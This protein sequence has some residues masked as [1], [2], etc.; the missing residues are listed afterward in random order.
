MLYSV[1]SVEK[2]CGKER[3]MTMKKFVF[4]KANPVWEQGKEREK[5]YSLVFQ[6]KIQDTRAEIHIACS[7]TYQIFI[8]GRFIAA[9][10]ARAAHGMYNVDKILL[11]DRLTNDA[12]VVD[13]LVSGYNTDTFQTLNQPSFLCAEILC[14][15]EITAAT[16]VCGFKA[17]CYS[18]R[19]QKVQRYSYQ[20]NYIEVYK[21]KRD[22]FGF[23]SYDGSEADISCTDNKNFF[24]RS[25][26]YPEYDTEPID[27]AIS[28]GMLRKC[29]ENIHKYEDRSIIGVP[30]RC[31]GFKREELEF[32]ETQALGYYEFDVTEKIGSIKNEIHLTDNE[33]II[34]SGKINNTGFIGFDV[35]CGEAARLVIT[36]DEMLCGDK[37]DYIRNNT[38]NIIVYELEKG[39]YRFVSNEPYTFKYICIAAVFGKVQ[40]NNLHITEYKFPK[41]ESSLKSRDK[42][43][44]LIFD[45]AIETFR[46][47]AVDL[48][49]DCPSRERGGYLCDSFFTARAEYALTGKSTIERCFLENY[50]N[51]KGIKNIPDGFLPMCYPSD[52]HISEYIPNWN[53]WFIAELEEYAKRSGDTELIKNAEAMVMKML[54]KFKTYENELGLLEKLDGWIFIEWSDSNKYTQDINFPT[55]M[56]YYYAKLAASRMYGIEK[57]K[58]EAEELKKNIIK[59]SYFDGYFHDRALRRGGKL[60]TTD[61]IT[62][63]AQYYAFFFDIAEGKEFEGLWKKLSEDYGPDR[64]EDCKASPSNAFIGNYL[65]LDILL[66][67]RQYGKAQAETEKFFLDMAKQTGTLWEDMNTS[68]SLCHGFASYAAAILKECSEN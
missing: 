24:E 42:N 54:A 18:E 27:Q 20:R 51:Y 17:F 11:N 48:Y 53:M 1:R 37:I 3:E 13:I 59:L 67:K 21:V 14:G 35:V 68:G 33:F 26:Y 5:N 44:N 25:A 12:D 62:E 56:L 9:G 2:L 34:M 19:M 6:T 52:F 16:G 49:T 8:N 22:N 57:L 40:I 39:R 38:A 4:K 47:N 28:E 36:F 31:D 23:E 66:K 63:T 15:D 43:L 61:E 65:R 32:E 50:I 60:V 45:A 7:C 30:E 55:N 41:I 10:P 29:G 46:Q 64:K 58:K